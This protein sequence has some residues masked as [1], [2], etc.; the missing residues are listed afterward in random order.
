MVPLT[1]A[2]TA[3]P[4]L[5]ERFAT[6]RRGR[7]DRDAYPIG[8]S[9]DTL[10]GPTDQ[11]VSTA[12]KYSNN[13]LRPAPGSA[14]VANLQ[15]ETAATDA[16]PGDSECAYSFVRPHRALAR[17][18]PAYIPAGIPIPSGSAGV[19][20]CRGWSLRVGRGAT[21]SWFGGAARPCRRS[22]GGRA[23]HGRFSLAGPAWMTYP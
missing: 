14:V 15:Q 7:S 23:G 18:T 11:K 13:Q 3:T 21:S 4:P 22:A 20:A 5:D 1:A 12:A 8:R 16:R 6:D 19:A 10:P 9:P 2:L 17:R